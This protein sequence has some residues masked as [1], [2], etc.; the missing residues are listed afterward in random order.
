MSR[1]L[2]VSL[3]LQCNSFYAST[4]KSALDYVGEGNAKGFTINIPWQSSNVSDAEYIYAFSQLIIPIA[5][6][7][8]PELIIISA[9]FDAAINDPLGNCKVTPLGYAHML[10]MLIPFA[11]GKIILTLEGG[12]DLETLSDCVSAC[13]AVLLGEDVPSIPSNVPNIS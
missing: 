1:V 11:N 4:N 2:F 10:K 9:G 5:C 8:N 12:Y 3:H 7:F 6:Q 13:L